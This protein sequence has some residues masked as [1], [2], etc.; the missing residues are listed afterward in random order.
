MLVETVSNGYKKHIKIIFK[1]WNAHLGETMIAGKT[2]SV[3]PYPRTN[4]PWSIEPC[5]AC[6]HYQKEPGKRYEHKG[7]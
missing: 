2:S 7:T 5:G 1:T 6:N 3:L 4:V